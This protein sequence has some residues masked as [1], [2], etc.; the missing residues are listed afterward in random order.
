MGVLEI[1]GAICLII[2]CVLIVLMVMLQDPKG[3][4]LAGLAGSSESYFNKNSG[5][6]LDAIL[7]KYTKY[8]AIVFFVIT[9]AV[10]AAHSYL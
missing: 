5:R 10:Y 7:A 4:G 8:A 6:T 1:I 9:I 2:T 3:N